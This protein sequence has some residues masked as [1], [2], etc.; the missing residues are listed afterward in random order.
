MQGH[1]IYITL[2][3]AAK[4]NF[5]KKTQHLFINLRL[6][7]RQQTHRREETKNKHSLRTIRNNSQHTTHEYFGNAQLGIGDEHD[8]KKY[9][10]LN[11]SI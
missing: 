11:H 7:R 8:K 5:Y 4:R 9:R 1:Y 2:K 6:Q 3:N 10:V